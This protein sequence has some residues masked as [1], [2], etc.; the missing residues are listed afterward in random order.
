MNTVPNESTLIGLFY[1]DITD[2]YPIFYND[3][4]NVSSDVREQRVY[5]DRNVRKFVD[6]LAALYWSNVLDC[7]DPRIVTHI[8][9]AKSVQ[10]NK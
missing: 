8:F 3:R 2:H 7:T 6:C 4:K 10:Y 1:T 9:T 5:D